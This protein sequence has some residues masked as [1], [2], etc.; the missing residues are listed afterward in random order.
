[1]IGG[2]M[3]Q[4]VDAWSATLLAFA[5][6]TTVLIPLPV[7]A[8]TYSC[9]GILATIIGTSGDDVIL[10]TQG[11]DVIVG[12]GGNDNIN[13]WLGDDIICGDE[14][15]DKLLGSAG[16]DKVYGGDGNDSISGGADNDTVSGDDGNDILSG[17]FGDDIIS[18]GIGDDRLLGGPQNDSLDGGNG[19]DNIDGGPGTDNCVNGETVVSCNEPTNGVTNPPSS[20]SPSPDTMPPTVSITSPS[21][22]ST[23]A[24][25]VTIS[26]NAADNTGITRVE[27]YV[28]GALIGS[29]TT[30]PYSVSWNTN[31]V[32]TGPLSLVVR[33]FDLAS[34]VGTTSMNVIINNPTSKVSEVE[35]E[36]HRLVNEER[37][38]AGVKPLQWSERLAEIAE[39]HS[40]DMRDKNY[41]S[42]GN[43]VQRIRTVC[44]GAAGENIFYGFSTDPIK[45]AKSAVSSWMNSPGHRAN[46]LSTSYHIEGVG[47][48]IS[49]TSKAYVTQDFCQ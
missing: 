8:P 26:A 43:F 30:N 34:N 16:Y 15:N 10:G 17:D 6:I 37:T 23:L 25:I 11:N 48:A 29:D 33:A 20:P 2:E 44:A 21:S 24:G 4:H 38:K 3:K 35:A 5:I 41:F 9:Q 36:I 32:S 28:G 13:G 22:G 1:M 18:G 12:L 39:Q 47:I 14:G 42:H 27:F 46:I 31:T 7:F 45:I 49:E 40:T 19:N